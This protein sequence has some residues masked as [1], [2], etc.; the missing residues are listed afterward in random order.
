MI[1]ASRRDRLLCEA[2]GAAGRASG[3]GGDGR[4]DADRVVAVIPSG[5]AQASD[6]GVAT[7]KA[8]GWGRKAILTAHKRLGIKPYSKS[9]TWWFEAEFARM[10]AEREQ[11]K[12]AE[13]N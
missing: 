7:A 2:A 11:A 8:R 12:R 6:R 3:R 10:R 4:D 1:R 5:R 9:R 13:Q